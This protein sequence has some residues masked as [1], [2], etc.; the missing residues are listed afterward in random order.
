MK[1]LD[2]WQKPGEQLGG[3]SEKER[4]MGE[5]NQS[6]IVGLPGRANSSLAAWRATLVFVPQQRLQ[7]TNAR[8][9]LH[10]F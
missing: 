6:I 8:L 7:M 10:G 3:S 2:C 4:G 9:D 5:T 1:M